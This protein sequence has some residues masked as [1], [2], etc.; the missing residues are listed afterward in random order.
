M[1]PEDRGKTWT[2]RSLVT[3]TT[4]DNLRRPY[5]NHFE[6]GV[7]KLILNLMRLRWIL[8]ITLLPALLCTT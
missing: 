1:E 3:L 5:N 8:T 7:V 6:L 4:A 2:F